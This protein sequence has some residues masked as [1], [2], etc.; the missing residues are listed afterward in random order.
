MKSDTLKLNELVGVSP[1]HCS[2]MFK[3]LNQVIDGGAFVCPRPVRRDV[4]EPGRDSLALFNSLLV[5]P[6]LAVLAHVGCL[7]GTMDI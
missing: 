4:G 7:S 2:D 6:S 3:V 1:P 5:F